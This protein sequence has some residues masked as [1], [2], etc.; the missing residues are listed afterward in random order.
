MS[1]AQSHTYSFDTVHVQ[2]TWKNDFF[3]QP[4][5]TTSTL[6]VCVFKIAM[7]SVAARFQQFSQF[8]YSERQ[9]GF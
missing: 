6:S 3:N 7:T 4:M 9:Y 8:I 5:E 2:Y 1:P